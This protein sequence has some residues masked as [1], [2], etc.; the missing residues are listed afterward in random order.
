MYKVLNISEEGR[1]GGAIGRMRIIANE[2]KG[3]LKTIV[4]VPKG[5]N[6]YV[7]SLKDLD[8]D[9]REVVLHPMTTDLKGSILYLI[10]F[11]P[12]IISLARLISK[13]KP[14]IVHCNGS[15]QVKGVIAAKIIGVPSLWHMNDTYQWR[16]VEIL[17]RLLSWLPTGYIYASERTMHYYLS[18]SKRISRRPFSSVIVAPVDRKNIR[19]LIRLRKSPIRLLLIGYI[20]I[21]KGIEL[22]LKA[23]SEFKDEE[24]QFDVVG[25][26]LSTRETYVNSL[27]VLQRELDVFNV[28][29]LGYKSINTDLLSKY[30]YYICSSIR[31]A[32]PMA[33]WESLASGLPIISTDVGDVRRVIEKHNCGVISEEMTGVSLAQAIKTIINQTDDEYRIMSEGAVIAS[34][35][36]DK[37][38]VAKHYLRFYKEV[39][40]EYVD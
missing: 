29:F 35:A 25:P 36:F 40:E 31:E 21:H 6:K 19:P 4:V 1:G 3:K 24:I 39:I 11:I 27:F 9:F 13:E 37:K 14:D 12:E 33:V 2:L 22:L 34:D 23:A 26:I 15:W 32:S 38:E 16:F 17:F 30:H 20:N 10:F 8:L 7:Q 18:L 28:S 5:S